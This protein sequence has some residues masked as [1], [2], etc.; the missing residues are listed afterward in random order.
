MLEGPDHSGEQNV[1]VLGTVVDFSHEDGIHGFASHVVVAQISFK[2]FWLSKSLSSLI[3]KNMFYIC[4]L[5]EA[6]QCIKAILTRSTSG[7]PL[8]T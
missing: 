6:L 1:T 3:S 8:P 5:C 2:F 7:K 4:R